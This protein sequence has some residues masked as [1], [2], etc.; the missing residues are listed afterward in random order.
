MAPIQTT[1]K[2]I[3]KALATF[4]IF[5]KKEQNIRDEAEQIRLQ[6]QKNNDQKK[7]QKIKNKIKNIK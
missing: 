7:I 1:K 5:L 3:A 2:I 6:A 4:F